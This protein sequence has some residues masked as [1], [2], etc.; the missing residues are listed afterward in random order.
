MEQMPT[1][2]SENNQVKESSLR[3][4]RVRKQEEEGEEQHYF[5]ES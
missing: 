3:Y 4:D 2:R 5:Y 1:K